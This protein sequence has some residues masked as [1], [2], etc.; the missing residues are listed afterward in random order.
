MHF[1]FP[2]CSNDSK[3]PESRGI[4][5]L[6]LRCLPSLVLF[7][8]LLAGCQANA[9]PG[10]EVSAGEATLGRAAEAPPLPVAPA[11]V[12]L[13]AASEVRILVYR[14]GPLARFGHNHVIVAPV[15]GEIRVGSSA[16]ESGFR[17]QISAAELQ[18]DPPAARAEEGKSFAAEVSDEARSGTRDNLLGPQ[19]LDAAVSPSIVISSV[20]LEGPSWNPDVTANVS[21]RDTTSTIEFPAAVTR[22]GNRLTVVAKLSLAQ[23]DLGVVPFSMPGGAL[24]VEDQLDVRIRIVADA[25]PGTPKQAEAEATGRR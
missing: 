20:R 21:I 10:S 22:Q 16:A 12:V 9:P 23:T 11:Y 2:V 13:P 3:L 1:R 24:K 17:L 5:V 4:K 7:T 15:H 19:V 25:T 6:G 8:G 18:V 14:G